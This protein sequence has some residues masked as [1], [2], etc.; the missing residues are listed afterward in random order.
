[1]NQLPVH[2]T[3]SPGLGGFWSK[4]VNWSKPYRR[5]D[6]FW[7]LLVRPPV[8]SV[9]KNLDESPMMLGRKFYDE[10]PLHIRI[11][12]LALVFGKNYGKSLVKCVEKEIHNSNWTPP[13]FN[14]EYLST[15]Q[16]IN[17]TLL[18]SHDMTNNLRT[19]K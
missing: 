6:L 12:T 3:G 11:L 4:L 15:H 10:F 17:K 9:F 19:R 5:V 14:R 13:L 8:R 18:V 2:W 16:Y 7:F 1:M